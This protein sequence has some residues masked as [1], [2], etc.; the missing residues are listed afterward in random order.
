MSYYH[1]NKEK[2]KQQPRDRYSIMVMIKRSPKYCL[3]NQKR[4]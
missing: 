2:L 4:L 1:L 3:D